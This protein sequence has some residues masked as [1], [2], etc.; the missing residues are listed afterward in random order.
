MRIG[1]DTTAIEAHPRGIGIYTRELWAALQSASH[2]DLLPLSNRPGAA[3]RSFPKRMV[4]MQTIL[5]CELSRLKPDLCHY[6]NSIAPLIHPWPFVVTIHDMTLSRMPQHH[7]WR[8]QLLIRPLVALTARRARRVITVSQH[9]RREIIAR[10][11]LA[12]ERVVVTHEAAASEFRPVSSAEQQRIRQKYGL[13]EPYLLFVGTIEPRKNL[14]R[15]IRAWSSLYTQGRIRQHL[16]IVGGRG[17]HSG[18]IAQAVATCGATEQI[19]CTGYVP[20]SDLAGLYTAADGFVLPSLGEGFGL[21]LVE[22]LACGTPCLI[23]HD[24]ALQE[25]ASAA[26]LSSDAYSIP[27]LATAIEQLCT[28][29]PLREQL[30][31]AGLQ[32]AASFSWQQTATQTMAIY[33]AC[34]NH[35]DL[36]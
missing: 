11:R 14:E 27:T 12:P 15:L 24:P 21:P 20:R 7:P 5:P 29:H 23:S 6:T 17:W 19:H 13:C 25:V 3:T 36:L 35:Q 26:A 22:A 34:Q 2:L 32:R 28:D 10:L 31:Q 30:R 9:A 1:Y 16:V 8:K 33:A 18:R 4:W